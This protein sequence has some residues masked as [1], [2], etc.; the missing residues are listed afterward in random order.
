[1]F[2]PYYGQRLTLLRPSTNWNNRGMVLKV[3]PQKKKLLNNSVFLTFFKYSL[4]MS[5][6]KNTM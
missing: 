5:V 4:P 6:L 2:W 1:M 3:I